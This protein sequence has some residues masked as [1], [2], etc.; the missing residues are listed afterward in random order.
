MDI[1]QI[2]YHTI[3][4]INSEQATEWSVDEVLARWTRLFSGHQRYQNGEQLDAVML[5]TVSGF[6]EEWRVRLSSVSWLMRCLNEHIARE[7]NA[8]ESI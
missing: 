3:L 1:H 8:G 6:A 7:A 5:Q 2:L 4:Q